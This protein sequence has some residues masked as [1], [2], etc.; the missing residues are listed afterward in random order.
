MIFRAKLVEF[1]QFFVNKEALGILDRRVL[2]LD[3]LDLLIL[4]QSFSSSMILY[5]VYIFRIP[6]KYLEGFIYLNN[7]KVSIKIRRGRFFYP[8]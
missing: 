2:H 7:V 5:L 1:L 8:N 4:Y 3:Y 6:K